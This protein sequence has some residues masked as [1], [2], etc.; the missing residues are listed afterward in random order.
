V[1]SWIAAGDRAE[2]LVLSDRVAEVLTLETEVR[3][4]RWRESG[5]LGGLV[6]WLTRDEVHVRAFEGHRDVSSHSTR[7]TATFS[8]RLKSF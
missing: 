1:L 7:S 4:E 5:L 3:G 2:K 6:G 8:R